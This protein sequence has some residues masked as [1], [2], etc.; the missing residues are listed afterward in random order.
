MPNL[1]YLAAI[2][3]AQREA[4]EEDPRVV[5]MGEDVRS[6]LFGTAPNFVELF[7][8]ERV[9]NTPISE[10]AFAGMGVGAAMTG[11]R[12]IV[13][14][15]YATFMYLAFD[16]LINQAAKNRYM[17]GGQAD[18]PVVY[19]ASMFYGSST[20]AHHSDR[21]YPMLMNVP[22]LKIITPATPYDARGLMRTA[23]RTDD[24]VIVFED[25]TLWMR[26]QELP[27]DPY[28]IPLGQARV[29]REGSDATLV[30]IAGSV[31]HA[32]AAAEELSQEGISVEVIDP[33]TLVPLDRETILRSVAKTGRLVIADPANRTC[34]AAS[35]IAA[36][37]AE[38]VFE[39]LR[40]PIRRI[41][42]PDIQ[43]PFSPAMEKPLYPNK[44]RIVEA[45]RASLGVGPRL[46]Q[47]G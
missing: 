22:G 18:I 9:I 16:Q 7:G 30:A 40:S 35:E 8:L 17:F 6:N 36:L 27:E 46:T 3:V 37:A 20:A 14:M 13:D 38:E 31:V 26:K 25:A 42:T 10:A 28:L 34:S 39:S 2:G 23:I 43:I 24:P 29:A 15:T 4:M 1:T 5:L 19:R 41:T 32:E 21:P 44:A 11:L 47:A 12:P 33:R 45:L